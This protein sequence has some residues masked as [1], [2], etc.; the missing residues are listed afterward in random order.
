[1][2]SREY[3]TCIRCNTIKKD[4][5]GKEIPAQTMERRRT[6][7]EFHQAEKQLLQYS[8]IHISQ[9]NKYKGA[10]ERI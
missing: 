7:K 8:N 3:V 10:A 1:M 2:S 9:E 5:H 4:T 6:D